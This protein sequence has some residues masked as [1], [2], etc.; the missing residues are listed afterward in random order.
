M[1]LA[2]NVALQ[3]ALHHIPCGG[4]SMSCARLSPL[5]F[6]IWSRRFYSV[7]DGSIRVGSDH[8]AQVDVGFYW[9]KKQGKSGGMDF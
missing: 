1:G 5:F 9:L 6:G 4:G 8:L 7:S 3:I 2:C